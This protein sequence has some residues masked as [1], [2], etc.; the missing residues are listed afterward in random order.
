MPTASKQQKG[1]E[2]DTITPG[3][4]EDTLPECKLW[5]VEIRQERGDLPVS[6]KSSMREQLWFPVNY[7]SNEDANN[8]RARMVC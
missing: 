7:A 1:E 5:Q 4:K 8:G 2:K 3:K 6:F